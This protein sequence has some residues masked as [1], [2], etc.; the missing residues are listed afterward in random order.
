ML[1]NLYIFPEGIDGTVDV[2]DEHRLDNESRIHHS[3]CIVQERIGFL[4][5][6]AF[7]QDYGTRSIS[8]N[9]L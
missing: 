8:E 2:I 4:G 7:L 5:G 6:Y 1:R 3:Q 9:N